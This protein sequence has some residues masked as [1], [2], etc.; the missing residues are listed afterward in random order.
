[1]TCRR[2]ILL[3]LCVG[4]ASGRALAQ[5]HGWVPADSASVEWSAVIGGEI[6][7]VAGVQEYPSDSISVVAHQLLR[8]LQNDGYF[9]AAIGTID[10]VSTFTRR[11]IRFHVDRGQR[12][13]VDRVSVTGA[14]ALDS[15]TAAG[16]LETRRGEI[17]QK[18]QLENDIDRLLERYETIGYP[19]ARVH[20]REL[21]TDRKSGRV[22]VVLAVEEGPAVELAGIRLPGA[23]RTHGS[24]VEDLLGLRP[25]RR[26]LS[27]DPEW[28]QQR[29]LATGLFESVG[30]PQLVLQDGR[31]AILEIPVREAPPGQ[32]D[33]VLGYKP[34][35]A[36]IGGQLVGHGFIDLYSVFWGGRRFQFEM[37]R[38]SGQVSE[39]RA[40]IT[41]PYAFGLP[42]RAGLRFEGYQR[43]STYGTRAL[44]GQVGY[45]IDGGLELSLSGRWK[46]TRPGV[47]GSDLEIS[48]SSLIAGGFG[49][50]YRQVDH[51]INP[52]KG[53]LFNVTLH[54][55]RKHR[56][57]TARVIKQQRLESEL[58]GFLPLFERQVFVMGYDAH[59]LRSSVYDQP[60]LFRIGGT[61]SLRGY[62]EEQFL[63]R[64]ALRGLTEYRLQI[65]R[66]SYGFVF[67]DAGYLVRPPVR[68]FDR[69]RSWKFGYGFGG[70][71]QTSV[72]LVRLS[73]ALTPDSGIAS[74]RVHMGM[75]LGL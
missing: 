58:R 2:F 4:L 65:D 36:E 29:L 21:A 25:G 3:L 70:Q 48:R 14:A 47:H 35:S 74:G 40:A 12:A 54:H 75:R 41:L 34:P 72:G 18:D 71:V 66:E 31:R 15:T 64:M 5:P 38:M 11:Q 20:V 68:S 46:V 32:F 22:S 44:A 19:L 8:R 27:Y 69:K 51:R 26:L 55:G 52:R 50:H 62:G 23:G 63:A 7:Q 17:L 28:I 6:S 10:T 59:V 1:M 60:D 16:L 13:V 24:H 33:F 30:E 45:R 43:D 37:D 53:W 9:W 39:T 67:A 73:Y 61:Q 42:V 49:M 56:R 57:D